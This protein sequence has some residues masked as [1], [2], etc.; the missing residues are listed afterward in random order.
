[1]ATPEQRAK[2]KYE[3]ED[4]CKNGCKIKE[5]IQWY[6]NDGSLNPDTQKGQERIE[7][8]KKS[9]RENGCPEV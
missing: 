6:I 5:Y 4:A 2:C 1:M 8:M 9:A 7:K 3:Y